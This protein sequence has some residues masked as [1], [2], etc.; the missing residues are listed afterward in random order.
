VQEALHLGVLDDGQPRTREGDR[1]GNMPAA[2]FPVQPPA[3]ER[4]HRTN[5]DDDEVRIGESV[6]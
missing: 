5:V 4:G 6:S 3:V 2:P 1:A